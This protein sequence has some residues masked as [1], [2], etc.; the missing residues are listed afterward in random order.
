MKKGNK[1][2]VPLRIRLFVAA[3]LVF[4]MFI[5]CFGREYDEHE[6]QDFKR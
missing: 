1:D 3:A 5:S 6:D 2:K 4:S